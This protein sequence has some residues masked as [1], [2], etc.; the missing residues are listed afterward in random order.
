[1]VG[2]EWH[3]E[4]A[5]VIHHLIGSFEGSEC[6]LKKLWFSSP[7]IL[8]NHL[9]LQSSKVIPFLLTTITHPSTKAQ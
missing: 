8:F 3:P 7:R 5:P 2:A 1:M 6:N 4:N 9:A